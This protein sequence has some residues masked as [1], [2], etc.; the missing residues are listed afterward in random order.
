MKMAITIFH[1]SGVTVEIPEIRI[2][3]YSKDFG[4]GF[5]CTKLYSQAERWA[6]RHNNKVRKET[7]TVNLYKYEPNEALSYKVFEEMTNEWLDF[8]TAC[9][10]GQTHSYD[11]VE[12][13]MADDTIWDYVDAYIRGEISRTAFWELAKF[14]HPTHQISFHTEAALQCLTF[15]KAVLV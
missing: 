5:Y 1:G 11:I 10:T 9:R 4:P 15:E 12:G 7:P 3:K 6:V 8:V 2:A 14:K 13:P